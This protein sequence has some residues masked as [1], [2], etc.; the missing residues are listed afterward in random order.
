MDKIELILVLLN[1]TTI[2]ILIYFMLHCDMQI[3][4]LEKFFKK[5]E[6][7]LLEKPE[8]L[9][10]SVEEKS[11]KT[12]HKYISYYRGRYRVHFYNPET[13][14]TRYLGATLTLGSALNIRNDAFKKMK[15]NIPD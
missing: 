5:F 14:K 4:N 6:E 13:K 11:R 8:V 2:L 1:V 7:V 12:K 10:Q 15:M 9:N 3:K